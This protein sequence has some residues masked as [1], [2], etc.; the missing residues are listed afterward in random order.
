MA[1]IVQN[2][3][4]HSILICILFCL[5]VYNSTSLYQQRDEEGKGTARATLS[6]SQRTQTD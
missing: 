1:K 6:K 3:P 5:P 4:F 2:V